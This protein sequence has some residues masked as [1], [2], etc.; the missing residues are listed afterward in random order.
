M[1]K[2][3]AMVLVFVFCLS[4][5]AC[6]DKEKNISP[7]TATTTTITSSRISENITEKTSSVVE[8]QFSYYLEKTHFYRINQ[9]GE[10]EYV[11]KDGS[12]GNLYERTPKGFD[13]INFDNDSKNIGLISKEKIEQI[14]VLVEDVFD[15]RISYV[16][17]DTPKIYI[18]Y[19]N[20]VF[21]CDIIHE[22]KEIFKKIKQMIE[23]LNSNTTIGL[24]EEIY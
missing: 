1:K 22:N 9:D 21:E 10:I 4:F 6:E 8:F 5:T 15:D 14:K 16:A 11:E 7:T 19:N 13:Y 3:I 20:Q 12:Y 18:Y 17:Q 23:F 2:I 24:N